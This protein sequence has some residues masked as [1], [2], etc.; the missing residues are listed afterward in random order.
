MHHSS[1][2]EPH[3]GGQVNR[4]SS[5]QLTVRAIHEEGLLGADVTAAAD[6]HQR[7]EMAKLTTQGTQNEFVLVRWKG[8]CCETRQHNQGLRRGDGQEMYPCSVSAEAPAARHCG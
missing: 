3:L 7:A 8:Q 5:A 4:L 2:E 6:P 1:A